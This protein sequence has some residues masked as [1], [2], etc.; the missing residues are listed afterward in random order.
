MLMPRRPRNPRTVRIR[1][2]V[3]GV[4]Q[5]VGFRPFV[6]RLA[7]ELGLA[8]WVR[9]DGAGVDIEAQ[10]SAAA[11]VELRERLRR[12]AP[13]LARVDEIGE[14]R[15]AAQVDADGF[16]ILESSRSDAAVHTAIG[17]DTAVCPDCLAELFDP[18]NRRYRYAFIN[19]TQCGPRYTL[20]WALPYDRATT[21][22]APFPQCRPCLDEY[23]AP[24]HRRFH[25]EPNACPDCGPSLAL[26]NA[27]GMPVE[28]VDPIAE[29]VAR[30]QRGEIVAIKG[31]GGFHLACDAHNADAVARLRS[32]K[33]REEKPFAVM[34]ANLATAAQWGDI[35]SG[36]AA[37]LTASERPIVL[38][39]KRSGVDGRFAGVA[40]G[41]V[42]L[43]VM[44]PYTPLQYLLFHEAAGRPEGLGWLA[45]PQSLVLVMTSANPG[46]EPLVTGN[47]EAAQ[48]LTGIADAF[49]LHDREILVRCDDSVVRG[50]GEPAPHVQFIRRARGYT[51]RAI[52]LARSGPSVLAL[53]GSFK[54][55]VC[56]TRGDEAFV[57]QHV[58]DLGNAAT[59]EALIEAVAH[60]QRVLE[61]RPQLV[62]HDLHPDFFS[63]RHAAELAAQWGVPAVAVQHHHAHIAAVLA[64]HGSDEPAIGLALDGV[65]LGDDGQ[66][67]G[68]E[69]LL[70]DGGACKRL[71]HLRELPL[72][73]GD[74]AAREPWRMAAAALHA[75]GRGEEIEGRFP[76]Q[77]GAPMVN[78]MLAQRLNAPLSSSMG[79][80]FD[81]AAGL[82]GTRETMAYEGQAAMLLE[83]LAES[84]GEQPSPGRPKTVA[85]SLGGVPR[86]GGG[87][88]KALALPDA[89]RIDAGNT[90][91]LLPLLEALSAETNAA[92]GAAQFHATL[93]A[94]LE[95]WTV[96][97]VQVTGV[98]TVVF[99]G[100]CFLNHILARNLCRRLAARGLTVLTARQ[101]PPNDGGIALGQVWVALQRAPN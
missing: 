88:Y 31:L 25:A 51:P 20:T 22:M 29:T 62:A 3:R 76:R 59:C 80:W 6:Y 32:R 49:L 8:G 100:G 43:G 91:D 40:P 19:C 1:I 50:D 30:L 98:R 11:L 47:D 74:R 67:W 87:T 70:V 41:L 28:D 72:P 95:A 52:K 10:G 42:W 61:I 101:L 89:W 33:Q 27:Q 5:G 13:P 65:G 23:N 77:P 12:D 68:G 39:R 86:S 16:A 99:G 54:N 96:A 21:S 57:S 35:G 38:L 69:L 4:V 36:E 14:E 2:R 37:L 83:G 55:T 66:A 7:R 48:R 26:L 92:R 24:E 75:M 17:H 78:R 73:G 63:T 46:G 60:L 56:L 93:V 64:E 81:A 94:A 53:G 44:L 84:W 85:H 79:R 45:Q 71:G 18:A 90:L 82:L 9:N 97:T 58:G 34:V 15:C